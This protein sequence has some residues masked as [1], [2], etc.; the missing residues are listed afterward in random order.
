MAVSIVM[1]GTGRNCTLTSGQN[2][3]TVSDA[4]AIVAGATIQGTGIPTGTRVGKIVGT[5]VTLVNASGV[6]VTATASGTQSL[7]FS[8]VFGSIVTVSMN[9]SGDNATPINIYNAGFGVMSDNLGQR[10]IFFPGGL[11]IEWKNMVAGSRFDFQNWTLEFGVRGYWAWEQTTILGELRGGYLVNGTQFIKAAGP[12]F[13]SNN[14]RNAQAG[15]TSMFT[16]ANNG[17]VTGTFRM[18]N[19]RIIY[20][21]GSNTAPTFVCGRMN[22][23]VDNMILDY[24]GGSG[25][26]AGISVAF[27]T[28]NNTSIVAANSGIGN[29]NS[30]QY[31]TING[32]SYLGIITD[33]PNH[34][35]AIPNNYVLEGYA[36]QV[37][38]TQKLGGFQDN[39]T[40]T[41]AN[42]DLS[43]AGWGLND[44]KVNYLRYGGLNE[45]RFPRRVSFQFN[46]STGADLTGVTLYIKS[47]STSIINAIQAGDYSANTQALVL[48]WTSS[49]A[50]YRVANTITDTISQIAQIRKYGYIE[51]SASYSLNL[52]AYS[53]PF[54]MLADASLSGISEATAS[55]ITTAG[56]NWTTKTIT[57]T[58]DLTYDQI[59]ARIAWELAQT[60]N[61]AQADPR[62]ISGSK[63]SLATGWTLVVNTGRTISAGVNITEVFIP[64]ITT[65]GTGKIEAIY[66][67]NTGT[68]TTLTISGFEDSSAVYLEDNLG[69]QKFFNASMNGTFIFYIPP[70]ASGSWYY[71]V[72]KY[73]N[74]RQSDFFTFSGGTKSIV[75][76]SLIDSKV[77]GSKAVTTALTIV[78]TPDQIYDVFALKRTTYPHIS[79]GQ[80]V[81]KEGAILYIDNSS[82]VF[83]SS[84]TNVVDFNWTTK[85]I[86]VKASEMKEGIVCTMI[87]ANPPATII[88]N[89]T[90]VITV[91]IEDANGDSDCNIQG[92]SGSF[93]I[94]KFPIATTAY[95][96]GGVDQR[97]NP[98]YLVNSNVGNGKFRFIADP[99][100]NY[101]VLDN[102]KGN[103]ENIPTENLDPNSWNI[104]VKGS[105]VAGLYQGKSQIQLA[106]IN[107][108]YDIQSTVK[109]VKNMVAAVQGDSFNAASDSLVKIREFVDSIPADVWNHISRTLTSQGASGATIAEI[110]ALNL[111]QEATSQSIKTKIDTLSNYNDAA[112]VA[113]IDAIKIVTDLIKT[114]VED[115]TGYALT[116]SQIEQIATTVESHLLNEGD[117][118]Q[119]INAIV[120][121]I[122]NANID[123]TVLV[124]A[125]RADLERTGGK[126]D[127]I[128]VSTNNI[129]MDV[130]SIIVQLDGKPTLA[131]MEATTVLAK[132]NT[133]QAI[134]D[135]VDTLDNADLSGLPTATEVKEE[136]RPLLTVINNGVKN[137]S[138]IKTHK[139]N[140]P[141]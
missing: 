103:K 45:I 93:S 29:P 19:L 62:T 16:G 110:Q 130:P 31:A 91:T 71:A 104:L 70:T 134:K 90:E 55:A 10:H 102:T 42:I 24:Q 77:I 43:S 115:K 9:A 113:K 25:A 36:P 12:T 17:A 129:E 63:V 23:I 52:A 109:V 41:F 35:F 132:E 5:T 108:V 33:S 100:Y 38:S 22:C 97:V 114:T 86:T 80:I 57:P 128:E 117:S 127:V 79:Y 30:G 124:S 58:A 59:N 98:A 99:L 32:L 69:N 47:G 139:T 39:T 85:L 107:E 34:K 49:V 72:E 96:A 56:I 137:A 135:K 138:K 125:I 6:E 3:I 2:T 92:G 4:T 50:S 123:E 18:N 122:G 48:N 121:A 105:Y 88:P 53:Q 73:G 118:Q 15:G 78:D 106:Q 140:L 75:V 120:G 14:Y 60:T 101:M 83:N 89:T 46:D 67:D 44:L 8:S 131:Q 13:I 82:M 116:N 40:E 111:A 76:K 64:T 28:L 74:Q 11:G 141:S 1:T 119:L 95:P 133:S 54:F 87:K 68:S 51:Q 112:L 136:L 84:A 61:S 26:N 7:I 37:L 66:Q 81:W 126:L 21:V 20:Q 65:I 94:F 27:G